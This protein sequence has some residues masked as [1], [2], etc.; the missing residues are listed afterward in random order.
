M[1]VEAISLRQCGQWLG[2]MVLAF[3]LFANFVREFVRVFE[4]LNSEV[5]KQ[6]PRN[7]DLRILINDKLTIIAYKHLV[8]DYTGMA[9]KRYPLLMIFDAAFASTP[10]IAAVA[11]Y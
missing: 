6:A 7:L 10:R 3:F 2:W 9:V 5:K 11:C 1:G 4:P 8:C